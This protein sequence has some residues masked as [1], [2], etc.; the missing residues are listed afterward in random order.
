MFPL[1]FLLLLLER[2]YR[3]H[4]SGFSCQDLRK[5]M[6]NRK[7]GRVALPQKHGTS[8]V[9]LDGLL[10][11][12]STHSPAIILLEYV[13]DFNCV[14]CASSPSFDPLISKLEA[15][16]YIAEARKVVSLQFGVCQSRKRE[17][18]IGYKIA[19][20]KPRQYTEDALKRCLDLA[21]SFNTS[22]HDSNGST[23]KFDCV[24]VSLKP[25]DKYL[26][27]EFARRRGQR[28]RVDASAEKKETKVWRGA[29]RST[30]ESM[31]VSVFSWNFERT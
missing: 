29:N 27:N 6:E 30:L 16:G 7:A 31:G 24:P 11:L 23:V 20:C 26:Q 3:V 17:Y 18:V 8:G 1:L 14:P 28:I 10:A 13:P 12:L 21:L 15:L 19:R 2:K 5:L 9:T 25:I 22:M 4:V